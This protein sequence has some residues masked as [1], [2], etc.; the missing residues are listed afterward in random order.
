MKIMDKA[1]FDHIEYIGTT[2]L[3]TSQF[4]EGALFRA[5]KK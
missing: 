4:T 5:H 3:S 2:G 1:G